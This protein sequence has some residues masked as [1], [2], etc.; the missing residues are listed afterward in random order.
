MPIE[1]E[2][3]DFKQATVE[4]AYLTKPMHLQTRK[5]RY[6]AG[7]ALRVKYP[8]EAHAEFVVNRDG[9]RDPI[10]LLIESSKGRVE[11]L[12][13]IRY[14]RM[15]ASSFAFFRGSA[16]IM[17]SDLAGTVS[18]GYAV[19][20][21]GDCHLM[22]FGAFATP[23]RNVIFDI[24]D[25]DET[26]PAPWEWDLKR[27]AA[28]FA[29]ASL[30]NEHKRADGIAA[31]TH[32]VEC[33]R[34]RLAELSEMTTLEAWYSYLPYDHVIEK[35]C[36][37]ELKEKRKKRLAKALSRDA[38]VEFDKLAHMVN[39]VPK[40]KDQPPLIYHEDHSDNSKY[41]ERIFCSIDKYRASLPI[42]RRVLFDRYE[43]VDSAIKVVGVG[44]VG[45]ICGIGL[46]FA[47][48]ADPLFLQVKEA[49][50]SVLEP[51]SSFV[52][53]ASNGERVVIGQRL[54]QA[55]SDFFLGHYV[56]DTGQHFYVRQLRDVK[57][58]PLVEIYSPAS[59]LGFARICG[60]ALAR[61]HARSGDP[62]IIA[63]YIGK[64][65]TFPDAIGKFADA[66]LEQ[67]E[68]DYKKLLDAIKDGAIKATTV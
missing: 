8:H 30:H 6:E 31:A 50:Q 37:P 19:Q 5:D 46:F 62:A 20:A 23:E 40:I 57:I 36:D 28:S 65:K 16:V 66:Y 4:A 15:Q 63:G 14:G 51:Y 1:E 38:S 7:R 22:N 39:G 59:M 43:L 53:T 60:W 61:A 54:M 34:D 11:S 67:N 12:L 68:S 10:E 35:T 45:T 42:E 47:A 64:K 55:A 25:F 18:T 41:K 3:T 9:R 32:L 27:L 44:S 26:F 56:G 52:S 33:Y 2:P 49:R 58:K 17:A 21:C 48:E 24:N 13:P 29:I